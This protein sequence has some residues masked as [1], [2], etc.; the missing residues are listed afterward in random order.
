MSESTADLLKAIETVISPLFTVTHP[1]PD[2]RVMLLERGGRR[3]RLTFEAEDT[4]TCYLESK[5]RDADLEA[6]LSID[7][8]LKHE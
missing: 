7:A 8:V 2:Y 6:R 1:H 4:L 5:P 3:Y